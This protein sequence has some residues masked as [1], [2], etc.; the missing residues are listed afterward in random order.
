MYVTLLSLLG[1]IIDH[2]LCIGVSIACS[3]GGAHSNQ[4]CVGNH[5]I[6]GVYA[7]YNWCVHCATVTQWIW[8]VGLVGGRKE[9]NNTY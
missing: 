4:S 6:V 2:T 5:S 9:N 3:Y 7:L 1:S 8:G